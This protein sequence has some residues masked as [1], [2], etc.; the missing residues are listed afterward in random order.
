[1][2][3]TKEKLLEA[4]YFLKCMIE[5]RAERD[6]FKFNL[7]AFL[8]T[9]RSVTWIMQKEF[10]DCPGFPNWYK[11]QQEKMRADHRMKFLHTKRNVT[12]KEQTIEPRGHVEVNLTLQM[13]SPSVSLTV[14]APDGTVVERYDQTPSEPAKTETT[15][16][17]H[18]YF[19]E[20]PDIDVVAVCQECLDKLKAIVSDC[21]QRFEAL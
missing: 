18:W 19:K 17:W 8:S 15:V 5:N 13:L 9:F 4:K 3:N 2:T 1:M 11:T 6:A 10:H 21:E 16:Q 14:T 12:I 20:F 7:S